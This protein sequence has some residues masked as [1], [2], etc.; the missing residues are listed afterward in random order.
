M[1]SSALPVTSP[2]TTLASPPPGRVHRLSNPGYQPSEVSQLVRSISEITAIQ[3]SRGIVAA[4]A[5]GPLTPA[6]LPDLPRS[7]S[8]KGFEDPTRALDGPLTPIPQ[9]PLPSPSVNIGSPTPKGLPGPGQPQTTDDGDYFLAKN[10]GNDKEKEKAESGEGALATTVPNS[11]APPLSGGGGFIGRLRAL[12]KSSSLNVHLKKSASET[13]E[14]EGPTPGPT[15][16]DQEKVAEVKPPSP[17]ALTTLLSKPLNRPPP[18]DVPPLCLSP[19]TNIIISETY[20]EAASGWKL[21]YQGLY[22]MQTSEVDTV[23]LER[24][25]PEWLLEFLLANMVNGTVGGGGMGHTIKFSF[26][27][28]PWKGSKE[29]EQ[30]FLP[31]LLP[32]CVSRHAP[33]HAADLNSPQPK[34]SDSQQIPARQKNTPL[35][36]QLTEQGP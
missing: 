16:G 30:Q 8:I 5:T 27:V 2:G 26:L 31:E 24:E 15:T 34:P 25:M 13:G 29:G 18:S 10:Q 9:S 36:T 20:S 6:I 23:A 33:I 7:G 4:I 19:L 22:G 3:R 11:P 32:R 14:Q 21:T 28:V 1:L 17:T 12:G 35:C